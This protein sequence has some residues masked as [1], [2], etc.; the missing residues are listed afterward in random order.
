M[1]REVLKAPFTVCMWITDYCNLDCAYCY[2][3]PF[4]GRRMDS[5]RAIDLVEEL[6]K[7]GV[8]DIT[9][10]GGEPTLH[11]EIV[12]MIDRATRGGMRIG[13]LSNGVSLPQSRIDEL[14]RVTTKRNFILQIS[15]D[16]VDPDVN[17]AARGKTLRVLE[18]LERLRHSSLEV[19]LATVVHKRNFESAHRIIE[20]Y[21]P[22]IK[23]FHFLNI[24]RTASALKKPELLLNQDETLEFWMRL[25]EYAASFPEDLFL[26]S[27]RV[28]LRALGH[29]TVDPAA[30]LHRQASFDC[31][32]CSAGW[33]HVNVTSDFD[34]L[35][36]DIAKDHSWMGNCRE[37][38]FED[39]WRSP[40]ANTI[41]NQPFPGCYKIAAPDGK[42]LQDDLKPEYSS[43]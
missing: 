7:M 28:Q 37:T 19:Q 16:S 13:L 6:V 15:I 43:T 41:R 27:L 38:S 21:Y 33:T 9:F 40:Q 10:A 22:D 30:S 24:Q 17:D 36:C 12:A 26:P 11:P 25:R 3:K 42:K 4:S 5:K 34:V 18:S 2:A 20:H 14:E 8:F 39:V 32:V 31:G 23:R 1:S 35:G 29:A